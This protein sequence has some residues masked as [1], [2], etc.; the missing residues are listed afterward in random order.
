MK[1]MRLGDPNVAEVSAGQAA[2][3]DEK[4]FSSSGHPFIRAGSL[5]LLCSGGTIHALEH[6]EPDI[7]KKFRLKLFPK[8]TVV[9]AKS[10][11]SA[12][13]GRVYRLVE[14]S[15][16]V[17]H[18]ATVTPKEDLDPG[19]LTHFL[20]KNPPSRLIPNDAYPSIRLSEIENITIELPLIKEQRR[21]AAILDK[22]DAIRRKRQ[23]ALKLADDF[24]KSVF[25]DMF[26]DPVTNPKGWELG[27]LLDLGSL[28]RGV[29]KHR[30]RNAP[31]LL[32]GAYPLVQTGEV[33]NCD[34]YILKHKSTYSERGLKQSKMWP[35]G[36]LCITI[37]ANIAKTGIL[38]FDACFP[39]SIVGFL[40]KD[41]YSI[42]YVQIWFSFL[43]KS[44]EESAP[45][46]AQKNINL[47][48]LKNIKLPIP[49]R[50]IR[51]AFAK[52]A[53]QIEIVKKRYHSYL[54]DSEL[55]V[56]SLQQQF[57]N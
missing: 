18:L 33:A 12:K 19:Y 11:M 7:A 38:N 24:L 27:T 5:D 49:T 44:L 52:K 26:G 32:G 46:S 51:Q 45:E 28:D 25:L 41:T 9:F 2:P 16:V 39:D 22:A 29:S 34:R 15:Y 53:L 4:Y 6:I 23:E 13:L 31:E 56:G 57:F 1:T 43:Q 42:D 48:I 3:Q 17:S 36:T 40:P 20:V 47:E 14:P 10:G 30:P 54:Q 55:F 35:K 21:I 8:D 50:E 37:A